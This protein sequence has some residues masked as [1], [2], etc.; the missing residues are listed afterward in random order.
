[1]QLT[2]R[3]LPRLSSCT[4]AQRHHPGRTS[5]KCKRTASHKVLLIR[6]EAKEADSDAKSSQP[7][8][9]TKPSKRKSSK[10]KW[11]GTAFIV[12]RP[13][14]IIL[15]S[16]P[17]T[18]ASTHFCLLCCQP[19]P[20]RGSL[21]ARMTHFTASDPCRLAAWLGKTIHMMRRAC[22]LPL[23]S[24]TSSERQAEAPYH[25]AHKR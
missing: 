20:V 4:A 10:T 13:L 8:V 7:P 11:S 23:Y 3:W 9:R 17:T 21:T 15:I 18:A 25:L 24:I 1:M 12:Q 6:V 14:L 19:E 5:V 2:G 22:R 16:Y